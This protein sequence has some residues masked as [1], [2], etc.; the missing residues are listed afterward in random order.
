[1]V[2][3]KKRTFFQLFLANVGQENVFYI[4]LE[5]KKTTLWAKKQVHKVK[6]IEIF[7]KKLT[8][9]F[10]QKISIFSPFF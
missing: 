3:V 1:M 6:K 10:G 8:H 7:P 5:L 2:L 4:I 9:G